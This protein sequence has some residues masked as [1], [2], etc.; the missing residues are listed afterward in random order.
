M[1]AVIR[2]ILQGSHTI[3]QAQHYVE[4]WRTLTEQAVFSTD[5]RSLTEKFDEAKEN[6]SLVDQLVVEQWSPADWLAT[7]TPENFPTFVERLREWV[8][9]IPAF[10]VYVP[11]ELPPNALRDL[12]QL[13]RDAKGEDW[14]LEIK[15]D[16][17]VIGGCAFIVDDVYHDYSL[18]GRLQQQP[19]IIS[20][21]LDVYDK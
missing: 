13:L 8:V 9:T 10:V 12:T 4:I 20:E 15:I 7:I 2:D 17:N 19:E 6:L 18:H 16:P 14:L 5:N 1:Q 11:V 3:V 21:I